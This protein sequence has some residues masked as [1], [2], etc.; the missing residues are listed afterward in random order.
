MTSVFKVRALQENT[1]IPTNAILHLDFSQ[2]LD[3]SSVT[4]DSVLLLQNNTAVDTTLTVQNNRLTLKPDALLQPETPY[5]I[6]VT[7]EVKDQKGTGLVREYI[8]NFLS[9][10]HSDTEAPKILQ[11]LPSPSQT[12]ISI[13]SEIAVQFNESID[14]ISLS[15]A[16]LTLQETD[17]Q[18]AV[19]GVVTL[20]NDTIRFSPSSVLQAQ[21][22]Y[23]YHLEGSISD[24]YGNVLDAKQTWEFTPIS[25]SNERQLSDKLADTLSLGEP[26][27]SM[28]TLKSFLIVGSETA[29]ETYHVD[30]KSCEISYQSA[31][32]LGS[33]IYSIDVNEEKNWIF[34][35]TDEGLY[36]IDINTDTGEL[37]N[38]RNSFY[39]TLAPVYDSINS[40]G[41]LYLAQ[42]LEGLAISSQLDTITLNPLGSGV[43]SE[44]SATENTLAA[45]DN[46]EHQW[47]RYE[48]DAE[49]GRYELNY[50]IY[51]LQMQSTQEILAAYGI[52]GI[53]S[54]QPSAMVPLYTPLSFISNLSSFDRENASLLLLSDN[55]RGLALAE[56]GSLVRYVDTKKGMFEVLQIAECT[57]MAYH[58]GT[59]QSA[60]ILAPYIVSTSPQQNGELSA[61]TQT[62]RIVFNE[63]I[64]KALFSQSLFTLR[65]DANQSIDINVSLNEATLSVTLQEI[66]YNHQDFSLHVTPQ[67]DNYNNLMKQD[68][69]LLFSTNYS[70]SIA[71]VAVDD[72]L[73]MLEDTTRTLAVLDNDYDYDG[74]D[75][76]NIASVT[77]LTQPQHGTASVNA[78]GI[79]TYTP[80]LDYFGSDALSYTVDDESNQTS[81]IATVFITIEDV[82]DP[83]L[84]SAPVA[85]NDYAEYL[86]TLL[87]I[88]ILAND[89]DSDGSIDPSTV[90]ITQH[91]SIGTITVDATNGMI[92]YDA[93]LATY[94]QDTIKYRVRD[95]EG[96][97]SSEA[98]L[99]IETPGYN[100]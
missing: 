84:N 79:L 76:I 80:N 98:T 88:D 2:P 3:P 73:T 68:Y 57:L 20:E 48:S 38:T 35:G 69:T 92:Y 43:I 64:D 26:L 75:S 45:I 81:N 78:S 70:Q 24:L 62:L 66:L 22:S 19:D 56:G 60:D 15:S 16:T 83:P 71:P 9:L 8:W 51:D 55:N 94:M 7:T 87:I 37:G 39:A 82:Y 42:T 14:P 33:K 4:K 13:Y 10:Q 47:I 53:A 31:L 97:L 52:G 63:T 77:L 58:D 21:I 65:D 50:P 90:I 18:S 11:T 36:V 72:T 5:S 32:S 28:N 99:T 67:Q 49:T 44:L 59:L 93:G 25:L 17:T 30:S 40:D 85:N 34:V 54:L 100:P 23:Q 95:N 86:A 27:L 74:N 1:K 96:L 12:S 46:T 61:P 29:L 6:K 89:T 41:K 91:P